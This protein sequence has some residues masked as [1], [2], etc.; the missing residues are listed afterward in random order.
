MGDKGTVLLSPRRK[1]DKG[2]VLLGDKGTVLLS[3]P[4]NPNKLHYGT[5]DMGQGDGSLVPYSPGTGGRFSRD[6]GTV[7]LSPTPQGQGDWDKG[8]GDGSPVPHSP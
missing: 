4:Q 8:Q 6:R 7:L 2:T 1:W 5:W 3:L